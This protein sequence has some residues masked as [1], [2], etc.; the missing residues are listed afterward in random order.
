[1]VVGL[2]LQ[3]GSWTAFAAEQIPR[4][5]H[6][7]LMQ[8]RVEFH[9]AMKSIPP[10]DLYSVL[11]MCCPMTPQIDPHVMP[12]IAR[13]PIDEW[14]AKGEP[15]FS[16]KSWVKFC[17]KVAETDMANLSGIFELSMKT[18]AKM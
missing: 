7:A 6:D 14:E 4:M 10:D 16:T 9:L 12:G 15:C 3:D 18:Q 1:M 11:P 8:K 5:L 2:R 13:Y 17:I